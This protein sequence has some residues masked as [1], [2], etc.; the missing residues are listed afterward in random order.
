MVS[1]SS[2]DI[3]WWEASE[4]SLYS[5]GDGTYGICAAVWVLECDDLALMCC[6][7]PDIPSI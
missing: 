4:L 3:T 5:Q 1:A 7:F 2:G 6:H